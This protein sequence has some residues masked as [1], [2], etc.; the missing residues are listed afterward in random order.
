METHLLPVGFIEIGVTRKLL[1]SQILYSQG[2]AIKMIHTGLFSPS[3]L[4][5][6][7]HDY[8][9]SVTVRLQSNSISQVFLS[10]ALSLSLSLSLSL[11]LF[12]VK[13]QLTKFWMASF[14]KIYFFLPLKKYEW[15]SSVIS[16]LCFA[17]ILRGYKCTQWIKSDITLQ[18]IW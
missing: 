9:T 4:S 8:L 3:S 12:L 17:R 15:K 14:Y 7:S 2:S 16:H 5:T 1:L 10:V 11:P 13:L 6:L 18:S